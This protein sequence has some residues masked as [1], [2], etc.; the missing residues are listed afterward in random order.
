[1]TIE[2]LRII[3]YGAFALIGVLGLGWLAVGLGFV[4]V[5]G[6]APVTE[7]M[8][9]G[10]TVVA[11]FS[12]TDQDGQ[13]VTESALSGRP[14]VLFFGFTYCP[15]ICPTTMATLSGLLGKMGP[16]ADKIGVYFVSVDPERDTVAAL[17]E[18]MSAFDPRMRALTGSDDQIAAIAKPL[19]IVYRKVAIEG[20]E[21]YTMDHDATVYL[22]N[23][24]GEFA[25]SIAYGEDAAT[26]L[27]KLE[28]LAKG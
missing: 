5:G 8:R 18:Y 4:D 16:E 15:E 28:R 20:S 22:V 9:I 19:G 21:T 1:M 25:G 13:T 23:A 17:K 27:K 26:A 3:R 11:P 2:M 12:L 7:R 10:S 14:A 24:R 6:R